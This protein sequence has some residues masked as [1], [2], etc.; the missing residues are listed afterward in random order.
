[1]LN[2]RPTTDSDRDAIWV[3]FHAVVS[4][5]DTYAFDPQISREDA[6]AYWFL[7]DSHT[8]VAEAANQL[9]VDRTH[10]SACFR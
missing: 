7:S 9:I 8:Y 3:I 4:P 1:V 6:L 5:G 10:R 2:I